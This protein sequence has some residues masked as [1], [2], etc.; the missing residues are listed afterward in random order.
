MGVVGDAGREPRSD[1][2][3]LEGNGYRP[4]HRGD[5]WTRGG[6]MY[7]L[8]STEVHGVCYGLDLQGGKGN[9]SYTID[10]APTILSDSHGTPNAVCYENHSQDSRYNPLG[11]T[12]ETISA[13]YGTG[14]E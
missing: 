10:V 4:T 1:I 13:K 2:I 14:G 7:T 5:G 11:E 12:C 3:C 6:I 9:A 8:N